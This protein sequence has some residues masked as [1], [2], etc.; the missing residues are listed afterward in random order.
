MYLRKFVRCIALANEEEVGMFT[1]EH[2]QKGE[3]MH[4]RFSRQSLQDETRNFVQS[5]QDSK[6][7]GDKQYILENHHDIKRNCLRMWD[8]N[9][10]IWQENTAHTDFLEK[11]GIEILTQ[12]ATQTQIESEFQFLSSPKSQYGQYFLARYWCSDPTFED[13][14]F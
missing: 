9:T 12:F 7:F 14:F 2:V 4:A 11:K 6:S 13:N 10:N 5:L 8:L 1:S 3:K